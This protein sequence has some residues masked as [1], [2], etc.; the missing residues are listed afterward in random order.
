M[1]HTFWS[2]QNSH[3]SLTEC[4]L[5][6]MGTITF[7]L[8]P[9]NWTLTHYISSGNPQSLFLLAGTSVTCSHVTFPKSYQLWQLN[10]ALLKWEAKSIS[11]TKGKM[12][13]K[14]FKFL[15]LQ[16]EC[17]QPGQERE[18]GVPS[19]L[20]L[21][22]CMCSQQRGATVPTSSMDT[23]H[24]TSHISHTNSSQTSRAP[25]VD[26][27]VSKCPFL[28][29]ISLYSENMKAFCISPSISNSLIYWLNIFGL[30][31][32]VTDNGVST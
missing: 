24:L 17:F 7:N 22:V 4:P 28:M 19:T 15:P 18:P 14:I 10:R 9:M 20:Q 8:P 26:L 25:E 30:R 23:S 6:P 21:F 5:K 12:L 29:A 13:N 11:L 2:S 3:Y 1:Q 27:L 32:L 31:N 16:T